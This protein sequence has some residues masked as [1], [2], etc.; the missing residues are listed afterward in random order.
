MDFA[1]LTQCCRLLAQ[2]HLFLSEA[3]AR[4]LLNLTQPYT[5]VWVMLQLGKIGNFY[6][7]V[8]LF[9]YLLLHHISLP[10]SQGSQMAALKESQQQ[11]FGEIKCVHL[12]I[13]K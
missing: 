4:Q 3:L 2:L 1:F 8:Y 13:N 7:L 9:A 6:L 12:K 11:H 5:N 10:F